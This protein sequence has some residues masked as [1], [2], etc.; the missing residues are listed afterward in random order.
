MRMRGAVLYIYANGIFY[1]ILCICIHVIV[2]MNVHRRLYGVWGA[3]EAG[4]HVCEGPI[5]SSNWMTRARVPLRLMA[6]CW[7]AR[8]S[9]LSA[10][11]IIGA[12][13]GLWASFAA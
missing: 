5:G 3:L 10:S 4:Q 9:L 6:D 8:A 12:C 2:I 1:V 7:P 13:V 11:R